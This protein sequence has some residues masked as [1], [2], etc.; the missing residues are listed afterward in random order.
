MA[1]PVSLRHGRGVRKAELREEA[2]AAFIAWR[3]A[4]QPKT[5]RVRSL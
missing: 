2:G 3:E 1:L 4:G 5:N